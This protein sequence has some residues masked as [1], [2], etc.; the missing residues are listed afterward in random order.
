MLESSDL[1]VIGTAG[2]IKTFLRFDGNNRYDK[3]VC[4]DKHAFALRLNK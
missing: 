2:I 3:K 1:E 4:L